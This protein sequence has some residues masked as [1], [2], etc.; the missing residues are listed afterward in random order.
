MAVLPPTE[1]VAEF[2]EYDKDNGVKV[3]LQGDHMIF[4]ASHQGEQLE[5]QVAITRVLDAIGRHNKIIGN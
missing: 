4:M 2:G 5:I 1:L 3:V